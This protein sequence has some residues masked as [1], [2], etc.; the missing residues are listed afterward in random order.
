[1]VFNELVVTSSNCPANNVYCIAESMWHA[2]D[3]STIRILNCPISHA[4]SAP[5]HTPGETTH[6]SSSDDDISS[7]SSEDDDISDGEN[8]DD[9]SDHHETRPDKVRAEQRQRGLKGPSA[10]S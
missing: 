5:D 4:Q 7:S 9:D 6:L 10:C 8:S 2:L 1:M 3:L